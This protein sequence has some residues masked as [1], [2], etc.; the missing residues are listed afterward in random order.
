MAPSAGR[1]ANRV[2]GAD[3]FA[4][5]PDFVFSYIKNGWNLAAYTYY[6]I[7]TDIPRGYIPAYLTA[8]K[9]L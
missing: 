8:T 4:F 5:Q 3:Y 1:S 7:N 2:P 6:E 9:Q